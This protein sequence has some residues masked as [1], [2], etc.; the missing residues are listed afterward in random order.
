MKRSIGKRKVGLM[1]RSLGSDLIL[2]NP[3]L[4]LWDILTQHFGISLFHNLRYPEI[5]DAIKFIIDKSACT[6]GKYI[7][8][9]SSQFRLKQNITDSLA[10]RVGLIKLLPFSMQELKEA[11]LLPD[12]PYNIFFKGFYPPLHDTD[13]HFYVRWCA[14]YSCTNCRKSTF[15]LVERFAYIR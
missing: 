1:G 3:N 4:A 8:T 5:F 6:P 14:T 12:E 10:G 13:K 15:G 7:L 9:G 11:G 2:E